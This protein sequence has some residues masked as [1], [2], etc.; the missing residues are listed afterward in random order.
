[1]HFKCVKNVSIIFWGLGFCF[2]GWMN[3][4]EKLT[5]V[6]LPQ[7]FSCLE[8]CENSSFPVLY[9]WVDFEIYV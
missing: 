1:M 8:M 2:E 9:R 4:N 6:S 5:A 7:N 3:V